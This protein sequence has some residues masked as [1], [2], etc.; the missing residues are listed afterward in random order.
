ML[1]LPEGDILEFAL[2]IYGIIGENIDNT[3][4]KIYAF[5]TIN[6]IILSVTLVFILEACFEEEGIVL[7]RTFESAITIVHVSLSF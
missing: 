3:T 4:K 1:V 2:Q 7:V 5:R 6:I